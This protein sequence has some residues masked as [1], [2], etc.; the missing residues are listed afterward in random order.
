MSA[1]D[2]F[3]VNF[4]EKGRPV[5]MQQLKQLLEADLDQKEN[6]K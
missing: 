2:Y 1:M 5:A 4:I 3:W 6:K